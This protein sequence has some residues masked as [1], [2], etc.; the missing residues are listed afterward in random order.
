V[1]LSLLLHLFTVFCFSRQP[2]HFAAFTV[3]PIWVWGGFGLLL[4]TVAFYFLRA[5]LSLIMTAVWAVTLLVA[6]GGVAD[7]ALDFPTCHDAVGLV[8]PVIA[9]AAIER[10]GDALDIMGPDILEQNDV[11]FPCGDVF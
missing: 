3:L 8:C 4:C 11:G 10:H 9:M 2:D 1:G 6:V 7:F 5:S